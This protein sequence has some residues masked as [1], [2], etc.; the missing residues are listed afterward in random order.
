MS[1]K[2]TFICAISEQG[3]I[4]HQGSEDTNPHLIADCL[5]KLG[6]EEITV[7]FESGSLTP[8]LLAGFKERAIHAI[9]MDA[10]KLSPILALKIN[11]TDK[12]DARGIADALRSGMYTPVYCK[13]EESIKQQFFCKFDFFLLFSSQFIRFSNFGLPTDSYPNIAFPLST[14]RGFQ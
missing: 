11:K 10:R 4:I 12:N 13:P 1:M 2:R 14:L 9:C 6:L 7:G 5:L 3:K 8:Y